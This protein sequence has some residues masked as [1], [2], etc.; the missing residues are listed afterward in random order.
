MSMIYIYCSITRFIYKSTNLN[1][2]SSG[3]N[4]DAALIKA[5]DNVEKHYAV[6]GVLEDFN[7][8][9][10]VLEHYVPHIFKGSLNIYWGRHTD[11]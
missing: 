11:F 2:T 7:K 5:K 10:A 9:L 6:V 4:T 1:F 3:F 8:T